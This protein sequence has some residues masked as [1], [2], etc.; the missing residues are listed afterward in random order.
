M[1][2]S[3]IKL[4]RALEADGEGG[5]IR[6]VL[7]ARSVQ[8][9]PGSDLS[10]PMITMSDPL[11]KAL[12]KANLNGSIRCGLEAIS[13]KLESDKKGIDHL[14]KGKGLPGGDRVSRLLLVSND[15][16]QRFYRHIEGL[17]RLHTPRL[18]CCMLD[19]NGSTMGSIITDKEKQIKAIMADHKETV[20]T[21]LRTLLLA[22][23]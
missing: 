5:A 2:I 4:P 8:L 13:D 3:G 14:R 9:W 12:Q 22:A 17:L 1:D 23:R 18:L 6:L 16:A 7:A 20:S 21:I 10:I 15:G 11:K 19:T